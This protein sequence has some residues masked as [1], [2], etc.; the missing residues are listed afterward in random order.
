MQIFS[1]SILLDKNKTNFEEFREIDE[2]MTSLFQFTNF[3]SSNKSHFVFLSNIATADTL[4]QSHWKIRLGHSSQKWEAQKDHQTENR[5]QNIVLISVWIFWFFS[6]F[7]CLRIPQTELLVFPVH[8][9]ALA[10]N[11][12]V[13]GNKNQ[14]KN[15]QTTA[16]LLFVWSFLFWS[17]AFWSSNLISIFLRRDSQLEPQLPLLSHFGP[18]SFRIFS[19]CSVLFYLYVHSTYFVAIYMDAQTFPNWKY[20]QWSFTLDLSLS[21][22]HVHRP[23]L[24]RWIFFILFA[25]RYHDTN[26]SSISNWPNFNT[27]N[28]RYCYNVM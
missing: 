9:A 6:I 5:R 1:S 28:I 24:I 26:I 21:G 25:V 23:H 20:I 15:M 4:F 12:W 14:N 19:A 18:Y 2:I 13:S 17:V 11:K 10:T 8:W 22:V 3:E 27:V 7:L 16:E